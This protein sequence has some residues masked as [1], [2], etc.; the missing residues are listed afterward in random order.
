MNNKELRE[1]VLA[2][3]ND[4]DGISDNA[5]NLLNNLLQAL[6]EFELIGELSSIVDG[7]D[8]RVWMRTDSRRMRTDAKVEDD[9]KPP[10]RSDQ[11]GVDT[12][13]PDD[14]VNW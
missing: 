14:P 3:L 11:Q 1:F 8:G 6:G 10:S 12:W 4:D 9:P 13:S 2:V 7:C 5:W